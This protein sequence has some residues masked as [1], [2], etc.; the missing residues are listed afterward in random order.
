METTPNLD[1]IVVKLDLE[2]PNLHDRL[3]IS[4]YDI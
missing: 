2:Y 1:A 3:A 4:G